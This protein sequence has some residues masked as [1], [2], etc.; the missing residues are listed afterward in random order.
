MNYVNRIPLNCVKIEHL[1]N[2]HKEARK[3]EQRDENLELIKF[4]FKI[5]IKIKKIYLFRT[6]I[7]QAL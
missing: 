3:I 6:S 1:R 2:M 5:F 4:D 7:Y